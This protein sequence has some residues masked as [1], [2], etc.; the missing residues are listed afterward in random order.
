MTQP[1]QSIVLG[2]TIKK[3]MRNG[4]EKLHFHLKFMCRLYV[5]VAERVTPISF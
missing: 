2:G 4:V 3:Y 5:A 1:L